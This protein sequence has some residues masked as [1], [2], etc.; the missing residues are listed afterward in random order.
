MSDR[1][2]GK[3]N[4]ISHPDFDLE[5]YAGRYSGT[6]K[7]IAPLFFNDYFEQKNSLQITSLH[8]YVSFTSSHPYIYI[9]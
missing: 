9:I 5:A 8:S 6:A 1:K 4:Q 2:V 7:V 3:R